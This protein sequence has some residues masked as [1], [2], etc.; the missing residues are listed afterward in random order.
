MF[1]VTKRKTLVR[2]F[3]H[4]NETFQLFIYVED[5]DYTIAFNIDDMSKPLFAFTSSSKCYKFTNSS[6]TAIGQICWTRD[7]KL[8]YRDDK[9]EVRCFR[10]NIEPNLDGEAYLDMEVVIVKEFLKNGW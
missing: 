1:D 9:H 7:S 5:G 2:T 10:S 3:H 6:W 8:C 4:E